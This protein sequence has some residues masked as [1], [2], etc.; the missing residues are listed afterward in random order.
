LTGNP[1][2]DSLEMILASNE[3]V[4]QDLGL[5]LNNGRS[6]IL[7][8]AHRRENWGKPL[9]DICR[10]INSIIRTHAD[11][12]IIFPVHLN[13]MVKAEIDLSI[14]EDP[15]IHL[16]PPLKYSTFIQIMNRSSLILTDSGGIQE[17]AVSLSKDVL[18]MRDV[19]ERKEAVDIGIAELVGS[20][21]YAITEAVTRLLN[22]SKKERSKSEI[23][24]PYGDGGAAKRIV[25]IISYYGSKMLATD[26]DQ[27]DLLE[28]IV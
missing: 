4:P 20:D 25:S 11:V 1:I 7:V 27:E 12:E 14:S 22:S 21:P 18:V 13:P 19:T 3:K 17:E 26:L 23:K 24:N 9:E 28:R 16:L 6:W 5:D 10:S 8:T 2:I 15:R